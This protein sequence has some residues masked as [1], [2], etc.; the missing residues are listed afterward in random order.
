MNISDIANLIVAITSV[1]A[2][3]IGIRTY[4]SQNRQAKCLLGIQVLRSFE[5]SFFGSENMLRLR[6]S[7]CTFYKDNPNLW[8]APQGWRLADHLVGIS[9]YINK[10]Y[11][12]PEAAW[13]LV[14][15]WLDKYWCLLQ[16]YVQQLKE[17][18]G[19]V[20]YCIDLREAHELLTRFGREKYGL[21][22]E[23]FRW[24]KKKIE[25]FLDDEIVETSSALASRSILVRNAAEPI[26]PPDA[27]R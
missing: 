18:E 8:D 12:E 7:V 27:A 3:I 13:S 16:P 1:T 2:L 26:I 10:G 17:S 11:I 22:S 14:Y 6:H 25:E 4:R 24:S 21:P 23:E 20:D 19:G 9:F 15:F 5:D